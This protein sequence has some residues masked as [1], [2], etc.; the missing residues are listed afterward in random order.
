MIFLL[1][2]SSSGQLSTERIELNFSLKIALKYRWFENKLRSL[3]R[4]VVAVQHMKID[5]VAV[6]LRGL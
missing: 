6:K 4:P 5:L 3:M 1:L 2:L